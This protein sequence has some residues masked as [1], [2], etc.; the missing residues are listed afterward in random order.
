MKTLRDWAV[1]YADKGMQT[2][3]EDFV[4]ASG[5]LA[6]APF[7][8]ATHNSYHRYKVADNLLFGGFRALNGSLIPNNP[9]KSIQQEDLHELS[10]LETMDP[11]YVKDLGV[12]VQEAFNMDAPQTIEGMSQTLAK[13]FFY[14]TTGAGSADGFIGLR[15][16]AIENGLNQ[17]MGGDEAKSSTIFVVRWQPGVMEGLFNPQFLST[18]QL[19]TSELMHGGDTYTVTTD[20]STGAQKPVVGALYQS[21]LGMLKA[22]AFNVAVITNVEDATGDKVTA[23][24]IDKAIE[25]VKGYSNAGNTFIYMNSRCYR[26]TNE[27]KV[28]KLQTLPEST[29]FSNR[30]A[31]WDGMIP[32]VIDDNISITEDYS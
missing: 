14:G 5:F 15:Q 23:A 18:G 9:T 26:L 16:L 11:T 12:S 6:T 30:M 28:S 27:L 8:P 20:T 22:G 25:Q 13:Q 29:S 24:A 21:Y 1:D 4:K 32:I 31:T 19:I 2:V 10:Q 7:R 3:I 17:S